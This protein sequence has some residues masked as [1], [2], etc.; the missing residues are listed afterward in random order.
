MLNL[1]IHCGASRVDRN[2]V[3]RTATP[4]RTQTW[5]PISHA[6]LL[7]LVEGALQGHGLHVLNQAHGL[8][9]DGQRYFG[10]MEVQNGQAHDDYGLVLGIRNSHDKSFP[11][12]IGLGSGVFVC[13]NLAFSAK[14]TIA[15]KH[16]RFIKRD[17]P[18]LVN[19]AV[20]R[21]TDMRVRQD[22]RIEAYKATTLRDCRVRDLVIRAVADGV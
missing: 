21:L 2:Q 15:R 14:A 10:L 9:G 5:V 12:S 16:T 13:D 6:R 3:E 11:A 22:Q 20:G 19:R 4:S 18:Q 17:L 7:D 8:W 1:L